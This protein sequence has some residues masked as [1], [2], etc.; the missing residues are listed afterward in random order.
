MLALLF[1]PPCMAQGHTASLAA[2][3]RWQDAEAVDLAA[4]STWQLPGVL[5]AH[6]GLADLRTLFGA[7]N[8]RLVTL[9][10]AEGETLR[11]AELFANDP[12][13]HAVI[14]FQDEVTQ[15]G[16]A[17]VRVR[18]RAGQSSRWRLAGIHLGMP[19]AELVRLNGAPVSFSGFDWDYAGSIVSW[20]AGHLAKALQAAMANSGGQAHVTLA[21]SPR[22]RAYPQGDGQFRSNDPRYTHLLNDLHVSELSL[23]FDH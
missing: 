4:A 9:D 14:F 20:H 2:V 17:T 19:L 7:A 12:S 6:Y 21:H 16:L 5:R 18:S 15:R 11:G 22:A 1:S 10:G 3:T 23:S 8:V 13:R